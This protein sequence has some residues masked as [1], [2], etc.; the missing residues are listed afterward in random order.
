MTRSHVPG[1]SAPAGSWT[2]TWSAP[3]SASRR[4]LSTTRGRFGMKPEKARP[5]YSRPPAS[6]TAAAADSRFSTSF[7]GSCSRKISM[8]LS[9]A[10]R[11]KRRTR[12]SDSGREPT[13]K[14]PRSAIC[15]GVVRQ[16]ALTPRIRSHGLSV[17]FWTAASKQPPP[18]T[19]SAAKPAWSRIL[20]TSSTRAVEMVPTSGCWESR[21]IVVSTIRVTRVR[22]TAPRACPHGSRHRR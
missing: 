19:S 2:S 9:A 4:A 22:C 1:S 3:S 21:R 14:R 12:S 7:R 16:R 8:P 20:A 15:S 11:M 6:R 17:P 13:R 5:A 10:Q 18:L